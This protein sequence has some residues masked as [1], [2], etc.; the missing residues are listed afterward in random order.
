MSYPEPP[1]IQTMA[2]WMLAFIFLLIMLMIIALTVSSVHAAEVPQSSSPH[3]H[4]QQMPLPDL[5]FPEVY[6]ESGNTQTEWNESGGDLEQEMEFMV[7]EFVRSMHQL[8]C[9]RLP[10]DQRFP[11]LKALDHPLEI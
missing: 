9:M 10:Y 4:Y 11:C 7:E 5:P 2:R 3:E 1:F 8:A 6:N